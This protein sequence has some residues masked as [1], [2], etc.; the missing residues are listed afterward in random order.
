[1]NVGATRKARAK[2][3]KVVALCVSPFDHPAVFAEPATVLGAVPGDRGLDAVLAKLL[4]WGSGR[5]RVLLMILG[6]R[7]GGQCTP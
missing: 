6:L 2:T 5:S 4:R 1:V 3:A 7:S